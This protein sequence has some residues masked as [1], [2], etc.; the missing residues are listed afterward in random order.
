MVQWHWSFFEPHT[1][2]QAPELDP[3]NHDAQTML[4]HIA[5]SI[6]DFLTA[7]NQIAF[8]RLIIGESRRWPWIAEDFYRLG[9]RPVLDAFIH[10]LERMHA[11]GAIDCPHPAIAAQQFLG[12]IQ[13]FVI[14][15]KVMAIPSADLAHL[16]PVK[17]VVD[18]AL[19][20][21]LARYGPRA[22][23]ERHT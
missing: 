5:S 18:E 19:A 16:P 15:P 4:R 1:M 22:P 17:T 9:K 2:L 14:W 11:A 12:L 21:F 8:T 7:T 20:M 10:Q 6:L 3:A 13:E 23:A